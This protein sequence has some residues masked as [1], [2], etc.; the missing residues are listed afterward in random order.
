M[1]LRGDAQIVGYAQQRSERRFTGQ[2]KLTLE[3]WADMA[4]A[5]LADAGID[6]REVDG[7]V[8]GSDI[9]ESTFFVPATIAEYMGWSVN[10]AERVDLGGA[11]P[12]GMVWRAAAAIEL[13]VCEVVVQCVCG[14]VCVV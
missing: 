14:V 2:P 7:L 3:Q 5:A 11:T 9:F 6:S 4:A 8:C 12:A 13:G 1:G 10:L